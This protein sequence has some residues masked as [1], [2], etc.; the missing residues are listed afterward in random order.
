MLLSAPT[1]IEVLSPEEGWR[2]LFCCS[3]FKT[4]SRPLPLCRCVDQTQPNVQD[5]G[6]EGRLRRRLPW[7]K[8]DRGRR[9]RSAARPLLTPSSSIVSL[10]GLIAAL[11]ALLREESSGC[12]SASDFLC[13]STFWPLINS[14][15][16]F[17]FFPF[18]SQSQ[19]HCWWSH[20]LPRW[21]PK[22]KACI[23]FRLFDPIRYL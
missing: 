8:S 14:P 6:E 5:E 17:Y 11:C 4:L 18:M 1:I 21:L 10:W 16:A 22:K 15:T 12:H 2:S 3:T 13:C 9:F 23:K 7:R 20:Q 19:Q